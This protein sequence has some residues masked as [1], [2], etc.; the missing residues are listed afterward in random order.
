MTARLSMA[1]DMMVWNITKDNVVERMA[2]SP[3]RAVWRAGPDPS[4][5]AGEGT[6]QPNER[7][8]CRR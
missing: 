3:D 4:A 5:T 1:V 6:P 8:H 7:L 2:V